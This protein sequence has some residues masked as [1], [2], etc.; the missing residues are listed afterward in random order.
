MVSGKATVINKK[1]LHIKPAG[2]LSTIALGFSCSV[3]LKVRN[4]NVNA[5]SVLGVLSAQV[6]EGEEIELVCSGSDEEQCL[7]SLIEGINSK[8]GLE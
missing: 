5:K 6:R 3:Y 2:A 1:G 4:Y 8:F 7:N